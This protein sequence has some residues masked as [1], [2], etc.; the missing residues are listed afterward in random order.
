[1]FTQA[2][3]SRRTFLVGMTILGATLLLATSPLR[4]AAGTVP[5][6]F[7]E[8]FAEVNGV[9]L[10]YLIGGKGSPVVLLHGYT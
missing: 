3:K 8:H 1:M 9:R 4:A 6:G 2:P 7:A 5:A 10:Y